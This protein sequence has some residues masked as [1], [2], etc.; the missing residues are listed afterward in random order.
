MFTTLSARLWFRILSM[1]L[2]LAICDLQLLNSE[3]WP[4]CV[5]LC[6]SFLVVLLVVC[7][8]LHFCYHF[9]LLLYF[10]SLL[11]AIWSECGHHKRDDLFF[12]FFVGINF[13]FHGSDDIR[14]RAVGFDTDYQVLL[15]AVQQ[16]ESNN[17]ISS[18]GIDEIQRSI[19]LFP[20]FH[21][22]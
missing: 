18:K 1:F 3:T 21:K 9:F 19:R 17:I 10:H 13:Y 2:F 11:C 14:W 20:F 12:P 15:N 6:H 4:V 7:F 22:I 5:L 8:C 16:N